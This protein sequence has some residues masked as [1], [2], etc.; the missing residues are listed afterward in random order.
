MGLPPLEGAV[1]LTVAEA[2]PAVAVTP[3][4]AP[5]TVGGGAGWNV[6][7]SAV[8]VGLVPP[9]VVTV[10]STVPGDSEGETAVTEVELFTVKPVAATDPKLTLVAPDKLVPVIDTVV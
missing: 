3:V 5:G 1:Q 10:T 9:G 4:G 7:W 2:L 8:L 6:Y